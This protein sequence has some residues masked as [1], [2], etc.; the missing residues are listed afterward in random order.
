MITEKLRLIENVVLIFGED[1]SVSQGPF[2]DSQHEGDVV[3]IFVK[4]FSSSQCPFLYSQHQGDLVL[5]FGEDFS[6]FQRSMLGF[7]DCH[8]RS[9]GVYL[10]S[11]LYLRA[12]QYLSG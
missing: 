6:S 11:R 8:D 3:L 7:N 2:L 5:I 10:A 9:H 1:F 12:P 4:G